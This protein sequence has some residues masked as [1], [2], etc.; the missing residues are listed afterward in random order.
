MPIENSMFY[1]GMNTTKPPFDNLKVRQA[2]AYALP[3]DK[4]YDNALYGRAAKLYGGSEPGEEHRLAAAHRLPHRH[5]QGQGADGRGRRAQWLRDHAQLRPRRRHH[6]RAGGGADAGS[7]RRHRHQ[8]ADQQDPRRHLARRAAEEG[9][10]DDPQP[11]RRL[12]GLPGVLLL[13]VLPRAERRVQHHELPEPEARQADH[14]RA[15]RRKQADLR[16]VGAAK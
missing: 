13:L 4:I 12:A 16:L 5:R 2:V 6:R 1:L 10:A 8:G 7:A 11:L 14:Q 3:Y 15:L 9:H